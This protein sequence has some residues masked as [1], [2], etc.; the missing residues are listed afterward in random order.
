MSQ[1]IVRSLQTIL[2][3]IVSNTFMTIAWYG[4]LKHKNSPIFTTILISWSIALFEYMFQ[5]PANRIGSSQ[6]SLI[7]LKVIQECITLGVFVVYAFVVYRET[8]KW[9]NIISMILIIA[10]VYF[11]FM[12]GVGTQNQTPASRNIQGKQEVN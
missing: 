5:V 3:L 6:F 2:L 7:Q 9:N 11:S 8:M 4:H 12:G 1:I 10:A